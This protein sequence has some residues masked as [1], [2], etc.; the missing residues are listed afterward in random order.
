MTSADLLILNFEEIRRRSTEIWKA[1]S[2][3]CYSW[4][5]DL[6]AMTLQE[7]VRHVLESE[8]LYHVIMERRG[9]I[10]D[11]ISP[12]TNLPFGTIQEEIEFAG[13]FRKGFLDAI[14]GCRSEE[15]ETVD[16]DRD[17]IGQKSKLGKYLLKTAYHE[18]VHAGQFLSYLRT[19]GVHRP[20][21]WD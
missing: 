8:H 3:E 10:G 13:P 11:Y 14:R 4:R 18:A 12:W 19:L 17:D 20:V 16:I 2:P 15:L 5:P 1:V 9:V 7:M 21:I 6:G